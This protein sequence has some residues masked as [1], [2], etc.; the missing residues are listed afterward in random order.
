MAAATRRRPPSPSPDDGYVDAAD[1]GWIGRRAA[2]ERFGVHPNTIRNWEDAGKLTKRLARIG[3]REEV[4]YPLAE[5]EQVATAARAERQGPAGP[6]SAIVL[7]ADELWRMVHES[8]AQLTEKIAEAAGLQVEL[9]ANRAEVHRLEGHVDHLEA[10][11]AAELSRLQEH[12][13]R[14]E[15]RAVD[16][17]ARWAGAHG[18][19]ARIAREATGT[20][21]WPFRRRIIID[22]P[23]GPAELEHKAADEGAPPPVAGQS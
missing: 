7:H 14:L 10:Q 6:G 5:L 12:V 2:A 21:W 20:S 11:H 13:E 4:R 9:A 8:G 15:R 17:E 19:L 3:K 23:A 22:L 16:A 1:E 18:E